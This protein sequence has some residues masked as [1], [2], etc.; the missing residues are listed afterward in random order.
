MDD[1]H[2][3]EWWYKLEGMI[4]GEAVNQ[5]AELEVLLS[6]KPQY[7][8]SLAIQDLYQKTLSEGPQQ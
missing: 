2:I 3:G 5:L 8:L 1:T 6:E 4:D 7:V